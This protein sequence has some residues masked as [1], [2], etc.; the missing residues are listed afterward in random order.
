MQGQKGQEFRCLAVVG[1]G[2]NTVPLPAA[3]TP[4]EDD[5]L[6]HAYDLA[7]ERSLLFVACTRARDWL[8]VSWHGEPS[9]FLLPL[10]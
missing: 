3:I 8:R 9:P 6:Q 2:E 1:V 5:E 7:R 10:L 4:R